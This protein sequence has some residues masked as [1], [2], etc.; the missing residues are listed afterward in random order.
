MPSNYIDDIYSLQPFVNPPADTKFILKAVS[1]YGCKTVS[2]TMFVKVY[3]DIFI[4]NAFTPNADGV[5]DTWNIPAL[6]AYPN[7]ELFIY[8]RYGQ[9][10]FHTKHTPVAWDGTYQGNPCTNG[11]YTYLIKTVNDRDM[12][13]GT[14]MI[15][16]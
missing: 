14:V 10:I 3:N 2:D 5:N 6:G 12:I 1:T 8:N 16:R 11:V 13:K 9:L 4:P 7:F 15:I